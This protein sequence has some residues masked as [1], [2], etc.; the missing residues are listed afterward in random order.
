MTS[1]PQGW[2]PDPEG[3]PRPRWWDGN[4]WQHLA[5]GPG[6]PAP[7]A[8]KQ[9]AGCLKIGLI[10]AGVFVLFGIGIVGCVALVVNEAAENIEDAIGEA[11][12][13]DYDVALD[14]CTV[15]DVILTP[16]ATGQITNT[17]DE[18]QGFSVEVRFLGEDGDLLGT[19][20]DFIDTLEIGQSSAWDAGSLDQV[21]AGTTVECEISEVSYTIF[22]DQ[23]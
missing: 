4:R 7:V 22:D 14:T 1:M 11:D 13:G 17:S 15:T 2:Y 16:A 20:V 8:P 19:G 21:A 18:A 3:S 12:A 6:G 10:V 9:G 5:E 23:G